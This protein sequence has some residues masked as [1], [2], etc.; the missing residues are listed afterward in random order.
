MSD[1]GWREERKTS[2]SSNLYP[3]QGRRG[4][5]QVGS[6]SRMELIQQRTAKMR[7]AWI[8]LYKARN[9]GQAPTDL[10][11][12]W[13]IKTGEMARD[14]NDWLENS[15][16]IH[17]KTI[18]ERTSSGEMPAIVLKRWLD[19]EADKM[20]AAQKRR[21]Y[22]QIHDDE[23]AAVRENC[24]IPEDVVKRLISGSIDTTTIQSVFGISEERVALIVEAFTP[25]D[26]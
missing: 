7:R 25:N 19:E 21:I 24:E 12:A 11:I 8:R 4:R 23:V 2:S 17:I 20:V 13:A 18:I 26:A 14:V 10:E 1:M 15:P 3:R 5:K 22:Q 16:T 9:N 6:I